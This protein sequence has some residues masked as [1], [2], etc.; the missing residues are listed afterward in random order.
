MYQKTEEKQRMNQAAKID[1]EQR[2]EAMKA[3]R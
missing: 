1:G 2:D 3:G